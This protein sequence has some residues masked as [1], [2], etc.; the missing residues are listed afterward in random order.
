MVLKLK[1]R[2]MALVPEA[3]FRRLLKQARVHQCPNDGSVDMVCCPAYTCS[4]RKALKPFR[5]N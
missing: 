4:L 2:K 5:D 1:Y 3:A